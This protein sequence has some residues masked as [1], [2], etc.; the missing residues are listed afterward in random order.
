MT[1]SV[2]LRAS[3]VTPASPISVAVITCLDRVRVL[4]AA[5]F[6][7]RD[8]ALTSDK[9]GHVSSPDISPAFGGPRSRGRQPGYSLSEGGQRA[10]PDRML[11]DTRV[12]DLLG[13]RF[14]L[15]NAVLEN[16]LHPGFL[17]G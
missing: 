16:R 15:R 6:V 13:L 11:L 14:V 9:A 17:S 5:P 7:I 12:L 10:C 4:L 3:R 8:P 1:E 2:S